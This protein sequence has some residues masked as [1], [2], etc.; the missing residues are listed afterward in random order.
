MVVDV[1]L[2]V[3]EATKAFGFFFLYATIIIVH[4]QQFILAAYYL[5]GYGPMNKF[6]C[7]LFIHGS[8]NSVFEIVTFNVSIP[9]LVISL[10]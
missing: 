3:L 10:A 8:I 4:L 2:F 5:E 1:E 9:V 6:L 7:L